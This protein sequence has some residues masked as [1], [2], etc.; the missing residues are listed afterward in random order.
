MLNFKA[1]LV[2]LELMGF[3]GRT[4]GVCILS[5]VFFAMID[6]TFALNIMT[7]AKMACR[8][9]MA[10]TERTEETVLLGQ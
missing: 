4:V 10:K 3:L 6:Q 8:E 9:S 1:F 2:V 5:V 7:Q